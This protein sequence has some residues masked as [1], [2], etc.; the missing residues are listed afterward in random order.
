MPFL[1]QGWIEVAKAADLTDAH[2][3]FGVVDLGTLI[4]VADSVS[5]RL[6]NLSKQCVSGG[7]SVEAFAAGRGVPDNPSAA[8][9]RD[10]EWNTPFEAGHGTGEIGGYTH[11]SWAEL[12]T[13]QLSSDDLEDSDW[14]LVFDLVRQ[15]EQRFAASH[16]RFVVW[17]NW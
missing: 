11:A 10:L 4:D 14:S 5:E 6:F 8:L 9:R 2:A 15:L 17:F 3:W 1:I 12:K 7:K 16:I 13:V